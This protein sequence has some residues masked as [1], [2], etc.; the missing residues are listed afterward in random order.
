MLLDI[1]CAASYMIYEAT[2]AEVAF[3]FRYLVSNLL[4]AQSDMN[5]WHC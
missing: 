1:P 4:G 2:V 5:C 3:K